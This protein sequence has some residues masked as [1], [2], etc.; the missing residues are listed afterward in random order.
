MNLILIEMRKIIFLFIILC[1]Y[2]C[3]N[4]FE[5]WI[6]YNDNYNIG[7]ISLPHHPTINIDT[8][9]N[10]AYK[11]IFELNS[12]ALDN[13]ES[14]PSAFTYDIYFP[15]NINEFDLFQMKKDS[16][17]VKQLFENMIK[18]AQRKSKSE[19]R[20]KSYFNYPEPGMKATLY[21]TEQNLITVCRLIIFDNYIIGTS[22]TGKDKNFSFEMEEDYFKTLKINPPKRNRK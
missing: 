3:K 18:G 4:R 7:S 10:S 14:S 20:E 19:V 15:T 6:V 12:A 17:T 16:N 8:A 13:K 1:F 21:S 9:A 5:N 11:I 22:A 2:G